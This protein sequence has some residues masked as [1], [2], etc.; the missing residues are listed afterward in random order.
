LGENKDDTAGR[1]GK[2]YS[3]VHPSWFAFFD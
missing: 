2:H 1:G 3:V